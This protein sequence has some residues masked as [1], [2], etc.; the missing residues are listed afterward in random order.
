M[1][2]VVQEDVVV[3]EEND[4][5]ITLEDDS[6]AKGQPEPTPKTDL[7]E[8]LMHRYEVNDK[9]VDQEDVVDTEGQSIEELRKKLMGL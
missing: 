4:W 9:A 3:H 8:G 1:K 7:P 6:D 5:G 2:A